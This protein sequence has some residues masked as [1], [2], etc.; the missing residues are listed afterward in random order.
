[1]GILTVKKQTYADE[2]K[3]I[4]VALDDTLRSQRM[5]RIFEKSNFPMETADIV[6]VAA[7]RKSKR[8]NLMNNT[9]R[10]SS[11]SVVNKLNKVTLQMNVETT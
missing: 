7:S 4:P 1:M 10:A 2:T 11:L 9:T 8:T 5:L 6:Q 3:L